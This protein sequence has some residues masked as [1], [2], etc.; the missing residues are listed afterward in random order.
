[1]GLLALNL[2]LHAQ[3]FALS[4]T[5]SVGS[6]PD[7]VAAADVNG[8]GKM[9]LI[10][11]NNIT[12]TLTVL[13]NDGSGVL[14]SNASYGTYYPAT[15]VKAADLNGDGKMDLVCTAND[16]AGRLTVFTNAGSGAFVTAGYYNNMGTKPWLVVTDVN[17]DGKPDLICQGTGAAMMVLTNA[18]DG[19]FAVAPSPPTTAA[20]WHVVA[21]DINEMANQI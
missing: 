3:G 18:G 12:M 14:I 9:D 1:M 17:G 16:V 2:Q 19:T 10:C 6:G 20:S 13:T 15:T 4:S 11:A 8:D 5:P 21:A 7:C